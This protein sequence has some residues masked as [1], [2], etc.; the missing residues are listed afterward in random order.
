MGSEDLE[1]ILGE[2]GMENLPDVDLETLVKNCESPIEK[3]FAEEC[4]KFLGKKIKCEGQVKYHAGGHNFRVD[5]ILS[6]GQ[7]TVGIECDGKD[8]HD[9]RE[10]ERRDYALLSDNCLQTIYRFRGTDIIR[11]L[12]IC[13]WW[14]SQECPGLFSERG[15]KALMGYFENWETP[16]T[17]D[18]R[19]SLIDRVII[20]DECPP[21]GRTIEIIKRRIGDFWFNSFRA[22]KT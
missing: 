16:L 6:D 13:I 10:D 20:H 12:E 14:I 18:H 3:Y 17:I 2:L 8:F 9:Y 11:Y 4:Y 1:H 7:N 19:A 5:F 15:R 22:S 21:H